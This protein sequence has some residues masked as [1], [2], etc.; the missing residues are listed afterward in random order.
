MPAPPV[1][2][3]SQPVGFPRD[4]PPRRGLWF[5]LAAGADPGEIR[6]MD[7]PSVRG[8]GLI[9]FEKQNDPRCGDRDRAQP[10]ECSRP[11]RLDKAFRIEFD[12]T[13]PTGPKDCRGGGGDCG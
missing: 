4:A 10:I 13:F 5:A 7:H 1:A 2:H 12:L 11:E 9:T 6:P 8:V 3:G